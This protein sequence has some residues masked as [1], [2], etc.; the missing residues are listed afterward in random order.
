MQEINFDTKDAAAFKPAIET[1]E[2]RFTFKLFLIEG[3]N[4]MGLTLQI[5]F[6]LK[7]ILS[8]LLDPAVC[9]YFKNYHYRDHVFL[10][11][12]EKLLP[13]QW[14]TKLSSCTHFCGKFLQESNWRSE[15][16]P[17]TGRCHCMTK[18]GSQKRMNYGLKS[19]IVLSLLKCKWKQSKDRTNTFNINIFKMEVIENVIF[20]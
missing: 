4:I 10:E 15:F 6:V 20:R 16:S 13:V 5:I 14:T 9:A 7:I 2:V 8:I 19:K 3:E 1:L 11:S 18:G 12:G 17:K